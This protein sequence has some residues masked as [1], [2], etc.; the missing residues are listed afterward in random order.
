[1]DGKENEITRPE[2]Y[3]VNWRDDTKP[4]ALV[5]EL[6]KSID[7]DMKEHEILIETESGR[8]F[9][10][11]HSQ[12]CCESVTIEKLNHPGILNFVGRVVSGASIDEVY[13]GKMT[14]H[15]ESETKTIV[16]LR[17]DDDTEIVEWIGTSNGYYSE[18]VDFTELQKL[19]G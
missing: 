17:C 2:G 1:M 19:S 11:Y 15:N 7:I 10:I 16:S 13:S 6:I 3:I 9:L 5:G 12:D 14:E 8:F 4:E 18:S